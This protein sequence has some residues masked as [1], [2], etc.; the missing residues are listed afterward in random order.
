MFRKLIARVKTAKPKA[1]EAARREAVKAVHA[2][3]VRG[4]TRSIHS[5]GEALRSLTHQALRAEVSR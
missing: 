3:H 1:L 2:A 5:A 4:D